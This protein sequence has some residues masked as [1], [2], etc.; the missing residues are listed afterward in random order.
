MS[1]K[2]TEPIDFRL[3]P[4]FDISD[5]FT[6]N[7]SPKVHKIAPGCISPKNMPILHLHD[8]RS[9]LQSTH[10]LF[11][12]LESVEIEIPIF[13]HYAKK[14]GVPHVSGRGYKTIADI[15]DRFNREAIM[16]QDNGSF[17]WK[18]RPISLDSSYDEK[19]NCR[20]FSEG[21]HCLLSRIAINQPPLVQDADNQY[22][23][24]R[25]IIWKTFLK[26][27]ILSRD[28]SFCVE[29]GAS[30][31]VLAQHEQLLSLE[32]PVAK[33]YNRE[34]AAQGCGFFL[35]EYIPHP[36]SMSWG[37]DATIEDNED[38]STIYR[39]FE[40]AAKNQIDIDLR[41]S[42]LRRRNDGT[43]VLV[44]FLE[45]RP[46]NGRKLYRE[47]ENRIRTFCREGSP[48][49]HQLHVAIASLKSRINK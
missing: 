42:N 25:L 28:D 36:F 45:N 15:K 21:S 39:F 5:N 13:K 29:D 19:E 33:L 35:F 40:I 37:P 4:D 47:L 30:E 49:Y 2:P 26:H 14:D 10:S 31:R 38:L 17:M 7:K 6:G 44:D 46:K 18:N 43:I 27:S 24:N 3:N 22:V 20:T 41:P 11:A 34:E 1:I 8:D 12:V 48:I 16:I 9:A 23:D 32:I